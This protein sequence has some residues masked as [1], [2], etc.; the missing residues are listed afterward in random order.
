MLMPRLEKL[1]SDLREA[2]ADEID[3][4]ADKVAKELADRMRKVKA[5]MDQLS[6][7]EH[8]AKFVSTSVLAQYVTVA[9]AA[10]GRECGRTLPPDFGPVTVPYTD[11]LAGRLAALREQAASIRKRQVS[12]HG[13]ANSDHWRR[14]DAWPG[15]GRRR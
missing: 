14:R 9:A 2:E 10:N 4:Q 7:L 8:G 11:Q 3:R 12:S 6:E 1:H 15:R 13:K 5:L